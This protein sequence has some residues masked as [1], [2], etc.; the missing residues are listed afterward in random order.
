MRN[1]RQAPYLSCYA[2]FA[3]GR[4]FLHLD[5]EFHDHYVEPRACLSTHAEHTETWHPDGEK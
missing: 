1:A 4:F 3:G 2:A 5:L